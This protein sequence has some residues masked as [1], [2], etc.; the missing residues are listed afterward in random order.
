MKSETS[1][2]LAGDCR[3]FCVGLENLGSKK[4]R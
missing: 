2:N 4:K 1:W 3:V